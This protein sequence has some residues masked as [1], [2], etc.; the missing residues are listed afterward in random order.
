MLMCVCNSFDKK[1]WTK[2]HDDDPMQQLLLSGKGQTRHDASQ[3][4]R[5]T[6]SETVISS[7]RLGPPKENELKFACSSCS[8]VA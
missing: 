8:S 4:D 7:F 6:G 3:C 1:K 5:Q 2:E